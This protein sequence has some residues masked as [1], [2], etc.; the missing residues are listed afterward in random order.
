MYL[1]NAQLSMNNVRNQSFLLL[2]PEMV[3]EAHPAPE[4]QEAHLVQSPQQARLVQDLEEETREVFRGHLV[5]DPKEASEERQENLAEHRVILILAKMLLIPPGM[6]P[7]QSF[8]AAPQ[9][10]SGIP[11]S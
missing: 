4:L 2:L 5:V 3:Q 1:L 6:G 8:Q 10:P 7:L 11:M 9:G